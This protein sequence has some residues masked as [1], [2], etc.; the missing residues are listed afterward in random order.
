[1][2]EGLDLS[3]CAAYNSKWVKKWAQTTNFQKWC[4]R[5]AGDALAREAH[6]HVLPPPAPRNITSFLR[7]VGSTL[8]A[9]LSEQAGQHDLKGV[10]AQVKSGFQQA[11]RTVKDEFLQLQQP[12]QQQIDNMLLDEVGEFGLAR[13]ETVSDI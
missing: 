1:M 2:V 4:M 6:Q 11:A 12:S 7:G 13:C 5:C 3:R 10:A 9:K 8:K